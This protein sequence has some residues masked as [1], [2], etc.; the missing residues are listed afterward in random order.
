[1]AENDVF[2]TR[3]G[4]Q[5]DGAL[6]FC[7]ACG[8]PRSAQES[9]PAVTPTAAAQS[10][11]QVEQSPLSAMPA[12][13]MP[14][15]RSRAVA[16]TKRTRNLLIGAGVIA[17]LAIG[18]V[19]AAF[20]VRDDK[21]A[22]LATTATTSQSRP[23]VA[24][25]L[26]A[27]T[28]PIAARQELLSR[29]VLEADTSSRSFRLM[30][31]AATSLSREILLAQGRAKTLSAPTVNERAQVRAFQ[32]AL[33]KHAR[34]AELLRG[35]AHPTLTKLVVQAIERAAQAASDAYVQLEGTGVHNTSIPINPT[36][37]ARLDSLVL[38]RA[39]PTPA[40]PSKLAPG[41]RTVGVPS[42]YDG[43]FTSVDRLQ[44]CYAHG[45]EAWCTSGPSG[46]RVELVAGNRA[47]GQGHPGSRDVGGPSM[48]E[49]TSFTTRSGRITCSS[50]YRGIACRD[51]SHRGFV[52]GDYKM[53]LYG[54]GGVRVG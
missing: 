38:S 54:A 49:G 11:T 29:R 2:C 32:A 6:R 44:R 16:G 53:F 52:I 20:V 18:G 42:V 23:S 50:S 10:R 40:P 33:A 17:L 12:P 25:Q 9:P 21:N 22:A 26:V 39:P 31:L 30:R 24:G 1:M 36:A 43:Y 51:S 7:T 37:H 8:E 35:V 14:Q 4:T 48:P 46:Q 47:Y 3:C 5:F 28:K 15:S 34:Y 13:T 41:P 19:A 45:G 27:L